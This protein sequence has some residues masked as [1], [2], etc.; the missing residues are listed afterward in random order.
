[1]DKVQTD[2]GHSK[3]HTRVSAELHAC[4][5]LI[6]RS[7][8]RTACVVQHLLLERVPFPCANARPLPFGPRSDACRGRA[9]LCTQARD[10]CRRASSSWRSAPPRGTLSARSSQARIHACP[11]LFARPPLR[12]G[13]QWSNEAADLARRAEYSIY[14]R[15]ARPCGLA[16]YSTSP[17]SCS[18]VRVP[19]A[20]LLTTGRGLGTTLR[21]RTL[22]QCGDPRRG[23]PVCRHRAPRSARPPTTV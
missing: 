22:R 15:H 18:T 23:H 7:Y 2:K 5:R 8:A 10:R 6:P 1:M 14:L 17:S 3:P 16:P 4:Y 12:A 20:L 13:A 11:T 21:A 9:P 19:P